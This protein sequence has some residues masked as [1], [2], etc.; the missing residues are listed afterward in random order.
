MQEEQS[1]LVSRL[2]LPLFQAR[3]WLRLVGVMAIIGGVAQAL[4]IVGLL[5]AWLPIW[6]GVLLFQSAGAL[7]GAQLG[8]EQA[9]QDA[10]AKL[11]TYFTIMGI[12]TLIGIIFVAIFLLMGGAAVFMGWGGHMMKDF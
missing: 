5:V 6:M 1:E 3:G 2:S 10:M 4:S 8:S 9:M 7:E 12:L 11:K